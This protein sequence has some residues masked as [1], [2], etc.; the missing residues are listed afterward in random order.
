MTPLQIKQA[1][2]Y[3]YKKEYEKALEIFELEHENYYAGLCSLLLKD[4]NRAY[5]FWKKDYKH[6][7]ACEWGLI[8]LDLINLKQPKKTPSFFQTRAFLEV[9][10][11]LF[12]ENGLIEW[13]QNFVSCCDCFYK[14]NP[15]SYKFIARALF[16]N[17]YF[18]LAITFCQKSIRIFYS[19]PEA[20]LI[21]SQCHFLLG[22]LGEALDCINRINNMVDGYFPAIIFE[23]I[24]KEEIE[25]KRNKK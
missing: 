20:F 11:N 24:I 13:A 16:S 21:L 2:E 12:I 3:F 8:I 17:G 23:K 14:I 7:K 9:Y 4:E 25:K 1:K 19:D 18:K 22:D 5:S 15:E 6:S 10:L